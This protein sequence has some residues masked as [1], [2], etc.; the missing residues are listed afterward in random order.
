MS[1]KQYHINVSSE[2]IKGCT[3]MIICGDPGRVPKISKYL[4]DV[5]ELSFN[6]EYNVHKGKLITGESII[7]SSCGIGSPSTAIGVEEFGFL[8]INTMIRVG[9]SGILTKVKLGDVISAT[10]CIRDEGTSSQYIDLAFPSIASVDVI[11]ALRE[12]ATALGHNK[13]FHEGIVHCKDAFYI[14]HP[15]MIPRY[16]AI[17]DRWEQ[18]K[19]G[20]ALVTE[21]ESSLLFVLASIRGWRAGAIMAAIGDTD[22]GEPIIDKTVGVNEAISIAIK[23]MEFLPII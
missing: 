9:T 15:K 2:D 12:A 19:K 5:E 6:R 23:A 1:D 17:Q 8:G 10:G 3:K 11:F 16:N 22:S 14:E 4:D 21:M 18:W 13:I 20:N 7:I